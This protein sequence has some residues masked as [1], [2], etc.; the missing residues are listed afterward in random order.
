VVRVVDAFDLGPDAEGHRIL[1]DPLEIIY[2]KAGKD[3]WQIAPGHCGPCMLE[4]SLG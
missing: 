1:G 4:C 3:F 2:I